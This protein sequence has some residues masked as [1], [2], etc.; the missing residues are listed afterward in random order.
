MKKMKYFTRVVYGFKSKLEI[1]ILGELKS[2]LVK[3]GMQVNVVLNSG[4][5]LGTW[6]I[7][8]VLKTDFINQYESP[9]FLGLV[10][11]CKDFTRFRITQI[12][13]HLRRHYH[14]IQ[15]LI[16]FERNH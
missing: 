13:A 4:A 1:I 8:E 12:I 3:E 9:N 6:T 16:F 11:R 7:K 2:G 14:H 5:L 15:P 10:I